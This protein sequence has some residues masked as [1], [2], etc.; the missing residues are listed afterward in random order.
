MPNGVVG[1][2]AEL[3]VCVTTCLPTYY[4]SSLQSRQDVDLKF[5]FEVRSIFTESARICVTKQI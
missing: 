3:K 5:D 2:Q 4:I 1:A